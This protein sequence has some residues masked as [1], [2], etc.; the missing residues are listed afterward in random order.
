MLWVDGNRH[1][2]SLVGSVVATGQTVEGGPVMI[3][4]QHLKI[5]TGDPVM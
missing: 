3:L 5:V 2:T 4:I 1:L